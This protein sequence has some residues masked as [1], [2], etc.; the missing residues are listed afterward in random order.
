MCVD[1]SMSFDGLNATISDTEQSD[2]CTHLDTLNWTFSKDVPD[3]SG[4]KF[5]IIGMDIEQK[6]LGSVH[7]KA[8]QHLRLSLWSSELLG[9]WLVLPTKIII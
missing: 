8:L 3:I 5:D 6:Y 2:M 4:I 7:F 1:D 9:G